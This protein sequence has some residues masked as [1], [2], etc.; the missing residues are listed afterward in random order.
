M[1]GAQYTK[2]RHQKPQIHLFLF[3]LLQ[4]E[5]LICMELMDLSLDRLYRVAYANGYSLDEQFLKKVAHSVS[6]SFF[7]LGTYSEHSV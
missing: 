3:V 1:S 7:R 4:G 6:Y 5:V 2:R